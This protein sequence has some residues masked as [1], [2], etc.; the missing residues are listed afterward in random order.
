MFLQTVRPY[1][2]RSFPLADDLYQDML[3]AMPAGY[4]PC[5]PDLEP[6]R[7]NEEDDVSSS[8]SPL[9]PPGAF[10]GDDPDDAEWDPQAERADRRKNSFRWIAHSP[11]FGS[12]CLKVGYA[13]ATYFWFHAFEG[14]L[15]RI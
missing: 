14:R 1:T 5:S 12:V 15:S 11:I 2:P 7:D 3:A 4:R 6:I 9:S 8:L 10:D 13:A